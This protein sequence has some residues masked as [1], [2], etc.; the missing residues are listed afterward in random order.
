MPFCSKCGKELGVEDQFCSSCGTP[1]GETIRA[2]QVETLDVPYP[3]G[4]SARL[5]IVVRSAGRVNVSGGA[6]E[7]F[8]EGTVEFDDIELAPVVRL[9]GDRV[10]ITQEERFVVRV[11]S[12]PVNRWDLKLGDGKPF[13]MDVKCGVSMGDWDL[14]GLPLT[15]LILQAGVSNNSVGFDSPNS[16]ELGLLKFSAGAGDLDISGLLNANFNR[17]KVEGG[18]GEV[19]LGF[20]GK[21]LDRDARVDIGG[22]VGSFRITVD[23]TVPTRV[24]VEGLASVSAHGGFLQIRSR[25]FPLG[26]VYT[27]DAY[28][29]SQDPSLRLDIRM[30]V[31]SV[32][33]DTTR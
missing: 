31:G 8:V 29:A 25:G 20:T 5:E 12:N 4:D 14:G 9:Q 15:D 11:R 28:E 22:G 6:S 32:S 33:L 18:V 30:G 16:E 7:K 10:R 27:N 13:S 21:S 19:R 24:S 1:V 23:E 2:I 3:E 17:M 26:G